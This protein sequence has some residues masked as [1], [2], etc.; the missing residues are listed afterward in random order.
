[1]FGRPN[2]LNK[3][4]WR[5]EIG[6][7]GEV[8]VFWERWTP[9]KNLPFV[10]QFYPARSHQ[11]ASELAKHLQLPLNKRAQDVSAGN[12]A[13]LS[14]IMALAHPPKLLLLHEPA[15]GTDP[16]VRA[17]VLD[18]PFE[19]L[20]TGDGALLYATHILPEIGRLVDGLAFINSG[21]SRLRAAKEAFIQRWRKVSFRYA[22]E[23]IPF[24]SVV[25]HRREGDEH[26]ILRSLVRKISRV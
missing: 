1:M 11:K 13:K 19:I 2:D 21:Q 9:A 26:P 23:T 10:S 5:L 24:Q 22:G 25:S 16:V 17:D 20:E 18:V 7:V 12:R 14:L 6:C 3:P 4:E 15:Y 8:H